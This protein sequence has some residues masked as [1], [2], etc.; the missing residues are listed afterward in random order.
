MTYLIKFN[1][2]M[3]FFCNFLSKIFQNEPD[4]MANIS[5]LKLFQKTNVRKVA[6]FFFQELIIYEKEISE[7][8]ESFFVDLSIKN[9]EKFS[10]SKYGAEICEVIELIHNHL[11]DQIMFESCAENQNE[12][13]KVRIWK[14]LKVLL[15]LS[16]KINE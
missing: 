1:E 15:F 14:Y 6:E 4:V 13:N 16:K 7:M 11:N 2:Q 3:D 12:T 10:E 8:N 9:R 5:I